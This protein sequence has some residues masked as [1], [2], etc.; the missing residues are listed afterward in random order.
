MRT[1]HLQKLLEV[2]R[3]DIKRRWEQSF[4]KEHRD[5]WGVYHGY[6]REIINKLITT[7]LK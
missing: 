1:D 5:Q 6:L 7:D 3:D 4:Y 2:A